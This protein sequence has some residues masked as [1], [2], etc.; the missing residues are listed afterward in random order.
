MGRFISKR[1]LQLWSQD[2]RELNH[3]EEDE[4]DAGDEPDFDGGQSFCLTTIRK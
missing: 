1:G 3:G 4:N 2:D